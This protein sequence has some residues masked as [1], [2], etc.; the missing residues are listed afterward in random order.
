MY[1]LENSEIHSTKIGQKQHYW[2][3]GSPNSK[4]MWSNSGT[5][6][7]YYLSGGITVLEKIHYQSLFIRRIHA[8]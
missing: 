5:Q 4:P 2:K 7:L 8:W 6:W 1:V 3:K